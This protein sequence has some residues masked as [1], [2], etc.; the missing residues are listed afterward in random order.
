MSLPPAPHPT[1]HLRDTVV[2]AACRVCAIVTQRSAAKYAPLQ[3]YGSSCRVLRSRARCVQMNAA[4][5]LEAIE[6]RARNAFG[7]FHLNAYCSSYDS[8]CASG[9]TPTGCS[10]GL[11]AR[12]DGHG[13][14]RCRRRQHFARRRPSRAWRTG[15]TGGRCCACPRGALRPPPRPGKPYHKADA[16][17]RHHG[18]ASSQPPARPSG[19]VPIS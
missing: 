5:A 14:N 4:R 2:P 13:A 6:S 9:A 16:Q 18:L 11:C 15:L 1:P 7:C 17:H 3:R 10:P 8:P 12:S 19:A